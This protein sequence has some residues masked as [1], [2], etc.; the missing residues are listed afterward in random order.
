[1]KDGPRLFSRHGRFQ[2]LHGLE[3]LQLS[4]LNFFI[5]LFSLSHNPSLPCYLEFLLSD[6]LCGAGSG[7]PG[8]SRTLTPLLLITCITGLIPEGIPFYDTDFLWG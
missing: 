1:M 2:T 6:S 5:F 7:K 4:R 3:Q 8:G